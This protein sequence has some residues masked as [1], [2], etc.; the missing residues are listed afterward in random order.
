M[1]K[2]CL[3]ELLQPYGQEHLVNH[4]DELSVEEKENLSHDIDQT[5]FAE[6]DGYFKRVQSDN[7]QANIEIDASMKPVPSEL[8]GS[9]SKSS[10]EQLKSYE[11]D[12]LKAISNN[13]VAVL[14]LAGGQGTRLGVNYPKGMCTVNSLLNKSLYQLQAERLVKVKQLADKKFPGNVCPNSSIPW[15]IMTSEHTQDATREFFEFND[16]FGLT[17]KNVLLFN[18][19][20]LPCLTKE[21]KVI[22][23]QKSKISQAPDGN[24]GLYKA[25][26]K[27]NI[28]DDMQR[29]GIKYIHV[30]CVDNIL[31]KIADPV[32]IGF[33]MQKQ[34]DC[35]ADRK[36]VV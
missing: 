35:A 28:L 5:D 34:A 24:G 30:Y 36:S 14:L 23:D 29:R 3:L 21:G 19:Y 16:Y 9:Y 11:S 13:E 12:G 20:M 31:I 27:R 6:L 1:N 25:I 7:D 17:D 32:F 22:L 2:Q 33:C 18:Q 4:W 8:K 26:L 10:L 15:Y